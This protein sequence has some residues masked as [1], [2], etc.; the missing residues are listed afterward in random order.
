MCGNEVDCDKFQLQQSDPSPYTLR[1][2]LLCSLCD[3]TLRS[4]YVSY[5]HMPSEGIL[6][7]LP[8]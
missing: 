3:F 8:V 4:F 2:A 1:Y 6:V 7:F 5:A